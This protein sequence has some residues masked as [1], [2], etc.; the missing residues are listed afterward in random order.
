MIKETQREPVKI[1]A[2]PALTMIPE[3]MLGNILNVKIFMPYIR[4]AKEID[5]NA[6]P[7]LRHSIYVLS[8][9]SKVDFIQKVRIGK[10]IFLAC[11]E[12]L[13]LDG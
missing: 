11:I 2:V 3:E 9:L 4:P 7:K 8:T 6:V 1:T 5:N 10:T 12:L 13:Q